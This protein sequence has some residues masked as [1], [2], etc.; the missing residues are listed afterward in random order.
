MRFCELSPNKVNMKDIKIKKS[1]QNIILTPNKI[2]EPV[3]SV[4][5]VPRNYSL[6][7]TILFGFMSASIICYI[8]MISSSVY[9]AVKVNQYNF[10]KELVANSVAI[11]NYVQEFEQPSK[12]D[13]ISYINK[14][15]DVSIT[16][17]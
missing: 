11:N 12:S 1:E 7:S 3:I 2:V 17:R 13:R 4:A 6:M 14:D 16:L 15:S 9:Y 10:Q 5:I 8:F